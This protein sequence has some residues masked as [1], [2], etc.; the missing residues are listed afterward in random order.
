MGH[1][2]ELRDILEKVAYELTTSRTAGL[3]D[4]QALREAL[5]RARTLIDDADALAA[6]QEAGRAEQ[7]W[8][9]A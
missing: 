8:G 7:K 6:S 5:R 3:E 4:I 9:P 2:D 1:D